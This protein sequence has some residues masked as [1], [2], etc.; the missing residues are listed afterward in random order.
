ML[1]RET[2]RLFGR[3][4][5][6]LHHN[7]ASVKEALTHF[8]DLTEARIAQIQQSSPLARIVPPE[9]P[10]KTEGFRDSSVSLRYLPAL[11]A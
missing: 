10:P 2:S 5:S 11:Q 1:A 4:A 6:K 9:S 8:E 3:R 7:I